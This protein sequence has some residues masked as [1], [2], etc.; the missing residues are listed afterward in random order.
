MQTS[1]E[2]KEM[3]REKYGEIA[4][5]ASDQGCM[6]GCGP[7]VFGADYSI[8]SDDYSKVEGYVPEADLSLGCGIPTEFA[9][10][11]EGD[12]VL[13]LGSGAGNDVFVARRIVG[14]SGKV[15]G[16]DMTDEMIAKA[17]QNCGK[18]G[19]NNVEFRFGDIEFLPVIDNSID[20][21]ISNCVL[22]LVPDKHKAFNE[23]FRVLKDGGHF[24]VSDIVIEGELPEKIR[25][26]V[27]MYVGCVAGALQKGEYLNV[28]NETGF[29]CIKVE[30]EKLDIVPDEILKDYLSQEEI[31]NYK[32]SGVKI[33]SITVFAQ[34]GLGT[35]KKCC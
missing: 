7:S 9:R 18:L 25:N 24:C 16:V 13:D 1:D 3:V 23:I 31:D 10:I 15:I 30:K 5:K 22:N 33:L 28:I 11:K 21:V 29:R 6:C 27:T 12:T 26:A 32:N 2:I 17:R 8:M 14:Q 35:A 20:V 4:K 34:K 19:Y